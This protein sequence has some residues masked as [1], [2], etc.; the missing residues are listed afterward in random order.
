MPQSCSVQSAILLDP[1]AAAAEQGVSMPTDRKWLGRFLAEGEPGLMDRS[2]RPTESPR[3]ISPSKALLIVELRRRKL[4][5]SRIAK[6]VGVSVSTV[7]RVLA[8]AGISKL[9]DRE[10]SEPGV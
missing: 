6:S 2:S 5:Q 10:P 1:V 7:S 4:I 8:R 9:S 3:A